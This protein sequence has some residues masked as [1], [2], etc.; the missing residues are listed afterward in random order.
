[1]FNVYVDITVLMLKKINEYF[2]SQHLSFKVIIVTLRWSV[3]GVQDF[4]KR[5]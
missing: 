1:M 3:R 2:S 5:H 4:L